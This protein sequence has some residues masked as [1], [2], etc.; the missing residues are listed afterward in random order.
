MDTELIE[1]L[2]IQGASTKAIAQ[3][4]DVNYGTLRKVCSRCALSSS[5]KLRREVVDKLR[6]RGTAEE[7]AEFL[8]LYHNAKVKVSRVREWLKKQLTLWPDSMFR[9]KATQVTALKIAYRRRVSRPDGIQL[10]LFN[11][12]ELQLAA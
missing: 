12:L 2:R 4:L 9:V 11:Q 5:Q 10:E 7:I 3:E 6:G 8:W 1:R